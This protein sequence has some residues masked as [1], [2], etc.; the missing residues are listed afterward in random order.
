M[1]GFQ[2]VI[3]VLT[4]IVFSDLVTR[5]VTFAYFQSKLEYFRSMS[6]ELNT[7]LN[8]GERDHG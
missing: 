3:G 4:L 6:K 2:S 7:P 5:V 8:Q 1:E